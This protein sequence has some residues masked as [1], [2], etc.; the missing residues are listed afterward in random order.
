ML[1]FTTTLTEAIFVSDNYQP[2]P[3]YAT[4]KS[5]VNIT[6]VFGHEQPFAFRRTK[7]LETQLR[8]RNNEGKSVRGVH[9]FPSYTRSRYKLNTR[10]SS[11]IYVPKVAYEWVNLTMVDAR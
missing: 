8:R 6:R 10:H 11:R 2:H 4:R 5:H 7:P 9:H 3:R 1:C